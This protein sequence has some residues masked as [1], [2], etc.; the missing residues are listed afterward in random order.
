MSE[1]HKAPGS[2]PVAAGRPWESDEE[3]LLGTMPNEDVVQR[4]GRTVSA[5]QCHRMVLNIEGF[6]ASAAGGRRA[7]SPVATSNGPPMRRPSSLSKVDVR[8]G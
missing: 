5:V 2:W 8:K 7:D 4:T 6:T 3:A 1:A